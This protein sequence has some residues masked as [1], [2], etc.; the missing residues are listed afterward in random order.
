MAYLVRRLLENT[1][2]E[3]FLRTRFG[4]NVAP[5]TLLRDPAAVPN[6]PSSEGQNQGFKNEPHADFSQTKLRD[7]MSDAILKLRGKPGEFYPLFLGE[8]ALS[9]DR[10]LVSHNPAAS[11]EVVGRVKAARLGDVDAAIATA[12]AAFASWRETPFEIRP[13]SVEE[14]GASLRTS[15]RTGRARSAG[16]RQDLG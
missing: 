11:H 12:T 8:S 1:S 16:D 4:E 3:G 2:N 9:T 6:P 10:E 5:E 13:R 14:A 15:L 7:R